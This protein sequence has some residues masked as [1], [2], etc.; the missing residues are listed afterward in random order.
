MMAVGVVA[1]IGK[2]AAGHAIAEFQP[3]L[4][5]PG[6]RWFGGCTCL[7][8]R[9]RCKLTDLLRVLLQSAGACARRGWVCV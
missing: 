6:S 3:D 2:G 8:I 4:R 9:F 1:N 5:P 7:A